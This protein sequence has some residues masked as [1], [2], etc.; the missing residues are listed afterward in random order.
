MRIRRRWRSIAVLCAVSVLAGCDDDRANAERER[1]QAMMKEI[2][3]GLKVALLASADVEAFREPAEQKRITAAL[4]VL[5]RNAS[6]LERHTR[7]KDAQLGFL[8]RSV[9]SDFP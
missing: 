6:A 9:A 1:T 3:A 5:T 7:S 2:F 8:A 4:E